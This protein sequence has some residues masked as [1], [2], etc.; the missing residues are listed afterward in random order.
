MIL[1]LEIALGVAFG[2][3][4][5]NYRAAIFKW[6]GGL[7]IVTGIVVVVGAL[8]AF[9]IWAYNNKPEWLILF[10]VLL[11]IQIFR[12]TSSKDK[13]TYGPNKY[14]PEQLRKDAAAAAKVKYGPGPMP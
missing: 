6:I 11:V 5:W 14:S 10:G 3:A 2:L 8:S 9:G 12:A 4:L 13:T 7:S 1:I